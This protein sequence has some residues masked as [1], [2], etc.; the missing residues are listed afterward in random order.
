MPRRH[1]STL[2]M[3]DHRQELFQA[4]GQIAPDNLHM[5]E[6]ELHADIWLSDF[7]NHVGR[8][9]DVIEK[10]IRPVARVN[11]LDQQRDVFCCRKVGRARKVVDEYAIG[12]RTR[13]EERRVGKEWRTRWTEVT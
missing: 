3:T 5:I 11:R 13:S 6:I 1:R 8:V 9:L 12:R 2:Q 7:C 4:P 10:I